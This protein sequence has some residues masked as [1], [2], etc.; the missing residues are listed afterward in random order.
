MMLKKVLLLGCSA[1]LV[2]GFNTAQIATAK[3]NPIQAIF[4]I[5][6]GGPKPRPIEG[7]R[8]PIVTNCMP[9][10]AD[11]QPINVYTR[12]PLFVWQGNVTQVTIDVPHTGEQK[13]LWSIAPAPKTQSIRYGN[14]P[15]NAQTYWLKLDRKSGD[16]FKGRPITI[17]NDQDRKP[18]RLALLQLD[19]P[20]DSAEE[21]AA[22]RSQYFANN[23][24]WID[25]VQELYEVK[26]PSKEFEQSRQD[27]VNSWCKEARA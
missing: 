25:A 1:S 9:Y 23:N 11:G 4:K 12:S 20:K 8:G 13:P 10:S 14:P 2:L 5:L 18:H 17:L 15:L 27:L 6:F 3:D 21:R 7:S 26:Q 16:A 19:Q 22:K 24:L